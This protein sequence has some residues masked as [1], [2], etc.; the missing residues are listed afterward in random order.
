MIKFILVARDTQHHGR[1]DH[2]HND[3]HDRHNPDHNNHLHCPRSA[4]ALRQIASPIFT[5]KSNKS[6]ISFL[7]CNC[8]VRMMTR[9]MVMIMV[10][11][12]VMMQMPL[13]LM[14]VGCSWWAARLARGLSLYCSTL[15]AHSLLLVANTFGFCNIIFHGMPFY[16]SYK[17]GK[18]STELCLATRDIIMA[19]CLVMSISR[20]RRPFSRKRP[21]GY[22]FAPT[23]KQASVPASHREDV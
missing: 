4:V 1:H 18:D 22:L 21:S 7:C 10:M 15:I 20:W 19:A 6:P 11:K 9:K 17:P 2:H 16:S 12:I 5:P 14:M 8:M 13:T 3:H 23:A